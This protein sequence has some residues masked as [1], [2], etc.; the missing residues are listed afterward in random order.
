[1]ATHQYRAATIRSPVRK[2]LVA[3]VEQI[4]TEY[5]D[6]G[7]S[8]ATSRQIY[9]Q[10]VSRNAIANKE[11]SYKQVTSLLADMRYWGLLDWDF[12]VDLNRAPLLPLEFRDLMHRIDSAVQNLRYDRWLGQERYVEV[13]VEKQA[14]QSVLAPIGRLLH[15]AIVVNKGYSS[16]SAMYQSAERIMD[17]HVSSGQNTLVIY[18]GDLDPS[19]EDM[20]RDIETRL[21]EFGAHPDIVKPA[22]ELGQVLRYNCPP[23]PA[24]T[25]DSRFGSY[26]AKVS[27]DK[28]YQEI[29]RRQ[30]L[31]PKPDH[32]YSWELDALPGNTLGDLVT[33]LVRAEITD[34]QAMTAI[35]EKEETDRQAILEAAAT[36]S[37]ADEDSNED[38]N[39]SEE[40]EE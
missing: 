18:L 2:A 9:Y 24:K 26:L 33:K 31:T 20:V 28:Q 27:A 11:E 25:T 13:W 1:M 6:N 12:I 36:I 23:N 7:V 16:A 30:S 32:A 21:N 38:S 40:G 39:E 35:I 14:L 34:Q 19:G 5:E 37:G 10:L 3:H 15:V 4:L 17:R 8:Q 22:L 29:L